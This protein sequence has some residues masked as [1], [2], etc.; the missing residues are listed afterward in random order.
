MGG[1][2]EAGGTAPVVGK[3]AGD[4][5][6]AVCAAIGLGVV[7]V[8][9]L[10]DAAVSVVST[11]TQAGSE[12]SLSSSSLTSKSRTESRNAGNDLNRHKELLLAAGLVFVDDDAEVAS[13]GVMPLDAAT[14]LLPMILGSAVGGA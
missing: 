7:A 2:G 3:A 9:V 4:A 10:L 1:R 11:A 14:L 6:S 12:G 13:R 8:A 5:T